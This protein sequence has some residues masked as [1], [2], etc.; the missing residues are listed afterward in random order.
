MYAHP[1]WLTNVPT[2]ITIKFERDASAAYISWQF[3]R[4]ILLAVDFEFGCTVLV[5]FSSTSQRMIGFRYSVDGHLL[6]A[7]YQSAH[8]SARGHR[9]NWL[10]DFGRNWSDLHM[11]H[12][13][14]DEK[15]SNDV[16]YLPNAS[17]GFRAEQTKNPNLLLNINR[18][19]LIF[20][21]IDNKQAIGLPP[22]TCPDSLR[23][24]VGYRCTDFD[25]LFIY[26]HETISFKNCLLHVNN[27]QFL[28]FTKHNKLSPIVKFLFIS[29]KCQI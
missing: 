4:I 9:L 12:W 17:I 6:I 1:L 26:I 14:F 21:C 13:N 5:S 18:L 27:W 19:P 16:F 2:A 3:L 25:I 28:R 8:Q 10:I 20:S 7:L 15:V 24:N 11:S 23:L 22:I 29:T